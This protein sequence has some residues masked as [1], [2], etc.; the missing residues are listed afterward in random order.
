MAGEIP[1]TW[2]GWRREHVEQQDLM[3]R[4]SNMGKS[5][6]KGVTGSWSKGMILWGHWQTIWRKFKV[7]HQTGGTAQTLSASVLEV[8]LQQWW[9]LWKSVELLGERREGKRWEP[10]SSSQ[11]AKAAQ[12]STGHR[13]LWLSLQCLPADYTL[14]QV[15]I[16]MSCTNKCSGFPQE[17]LWAT[18]ECIF[19]FFH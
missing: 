15:K 13:F 14:H 6:E 9:R 5:G 10:S 7:V 17:I 16:C 19:L 18:K 11:L 3:C 4:W 12:L 2:Q 8:Q 1:E